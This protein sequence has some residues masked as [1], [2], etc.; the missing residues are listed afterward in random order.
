[1]CK[2]LDISAPKVVQQKPKF[3]RK[4]EQ[5]R[6]TTHILPPLSTV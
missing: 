6:N 3:L 1:M 4:P 2:H 5:H